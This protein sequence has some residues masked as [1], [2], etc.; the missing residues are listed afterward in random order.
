MEISPLQRNVRAAELPLERLAGNAQVDEADKLA[1]ATRQFEAVL[2]RQI[3]SE[4]QK[5]AFASS[6]NPQSVAGDIYK[7]MIT[8]CLADSISRSGALGL[9][10]GLKH[11]FR[12]NSTQ[13]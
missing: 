13:D 8:D 10:D 3:L 12:K 2:L 1:E 11:Q 9:A 6:A 4:A 5:T 7:D